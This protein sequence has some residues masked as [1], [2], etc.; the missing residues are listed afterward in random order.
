[1]AH[2]GLH[3]GLHWPAA[4]EWCEPHLHASD[5]VF[6]VFVTE[7]ETD[8]EI[9]GMEPNK[10]WGAGP[11]KDFASLVAYLGELQEK[12]LRSVMFFGVVEDKDATGTAADR[13]DTPVIS[14]IKAIRKGLPD[15][16]CL[17]D[18][19][20]CE[21]TDHGHC[22]VLRS[23]DEED[24]ICNASTVPRLANIALAYARAGAH[25]VC[26]SDM[27]DGRIREMRDT[28]DKEGFPHVAIMAYTS[29]KA[30]SMYAPFRA[31]VDS[32]FTGDRK[33]YQQPLGSLVQA[34]QALLRDQA[35]GASVVLVKP[36]LFYGDIIAEFARNAHVPVACYVVSGEY[37]MLKD[38]AKRA[39]ELESVLRESHVGLLRAGASIL[40]TYFTP[41]LLDLIPK[42][43]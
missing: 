5:L 13:H 37:V 14:A 23:V 38:Y 30:S 25:W 36:S 16:M 7:R 17:A 28:L 43:R 19:C 11:N 34:R 10:Q 3:A 40:V 22:G 2:S 35:E 18:V 31:A 1:M 9:V 29:K 20:L 21:Y 4:R 6:P 39:G 26:P 33:R 27:M 24:V 42:W 32:T 41:E 12:G 8:K 15:L